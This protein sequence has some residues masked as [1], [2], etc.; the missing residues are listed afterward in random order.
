MCLA[1]CFAL[2]L[3]PFV[4]AQGSIEAQGGNISALAIFGS[5]QTPYWQGFAGDVFF[6]PPSS[7]SVNATGS[8]V[9]LSDLRFELPCNPLSISGFIVFSN[10]SSPPSVFNAGNLTLLDSFMVGSYDDSG[11]KTFTKKTT[12]I[13]G[14]SIVNNV[15]TTYTYVNS[16]SQ[17]SSFRE[18]YFNDAKNNL[19]FATE[20]QQDLTGYNGSKFDFQVMLPTPRYGSIIYY[21]S[22]A[23]NVTCPVQP[24]P[25]GGG[26]VHYTAVGYECTN[27]TVCIEGFQYR[28]CTPVDMFGNRIRVPYYIKLPMPST[29]KVCPYPERPAPMS[30][31]ELIGHLKAVPPTINSSNSLEL[32]IRETASLPASVHNPNPESIEQ[33]SFA[34]AVPLVITKTDPLHVNPLFYKPFFG[35]FARRVSFAGN[36]WFIWSDPPTRLLPDSDIFHKLRI[37]P[38]VMFP[39]KVDAQLRVLSAGVPLASKKVELQVNVRPFKA[40]V[41]RYFNHVQFYLVFDNRNKRERNVEVEVDWDKGRKTLFTEVYSLHLK[42]D[43]VNIFSYDYTPDFEFDYVIARFDGK[44]YLA[45]VV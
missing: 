17:N 2:F 39:K 32:F 31:F 16:S 38:P 13:I 34:L 28:N 40:I 29:V 35:M 15:P 36:S 19:V 8:Y 1:L 42:E 14:G 7:T 21:V 27:W 43:E 5:S 30:E 26:G 4:F 41:E 3:L 18:G 24:T 37:S 11:S 23:L 25:Q 6:I 10:S 44:K 20:F 33:V 12:F 9:N 45:E 22:G